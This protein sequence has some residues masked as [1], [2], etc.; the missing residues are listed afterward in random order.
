MRALDLFDVSCKLKLVKKHWAEAEVQSQPKG[1]TADCQ[2]NI[3][4]SINMHCVAVSYK[5]GC[6]VLSVCQ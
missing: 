3:F 5:I 4:A 1:Y 2:V 6:K